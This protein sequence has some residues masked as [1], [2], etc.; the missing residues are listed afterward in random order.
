MHLHESDAIPARPAELERRL[1]ALRARA[2]D[3][4]YRR[5]ISNVD[6]AGDEHESAAR[7]LRDAAPAVSVAFNTLAAMT[8]W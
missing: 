8:F 3:V 6:L 1:E 5:M 4:E 7:M 2:A